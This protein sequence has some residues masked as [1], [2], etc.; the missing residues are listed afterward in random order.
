MPRCST[1]KVSAAFHELIDGQCHH[2]T[3]SEL[4]KLRQKATGHHICRCD[5]CRTLWPDE[6][7]QIRELP[8]RTII[9]LVEDIRKLQSPEPI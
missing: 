8:H 6:E 7:P 5:T 2:C 3:H 4:A 9:G 1:C